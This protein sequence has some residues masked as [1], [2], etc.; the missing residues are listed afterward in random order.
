MPQLE[1]FFAYFIEIYKDGQIV[2][3]G[4][5]HEVDTFFIESFINI[6]VFILIIY[7]ISR[8]AHFFSNTK[9]K[10]NEIDKKL[11]ELKD[12]IESKN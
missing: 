3:Q 12:I 2:D 4:R 8:V 5:G 9:A 7:L 10:I 6:L 11:D 1:G